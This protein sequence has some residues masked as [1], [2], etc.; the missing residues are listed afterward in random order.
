MVMQSAGAGEEEG[1]EGEEG[2]SIILHKCLWCACVCLCV[3]V[4]MCVSICVS[5]H[6]CVYLSVCAC[7]IRR[8][9]HMCLHVSRQEK[10]V[11]DCARIF[12]CPAV[13]ASNA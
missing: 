3:C 1:E 11:S 13:H 6:V 4:Y 8:I 7:V 12:V 2:S 9:E 5:V 10:R